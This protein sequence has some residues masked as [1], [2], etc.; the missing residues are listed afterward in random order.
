MCISEKS[1]KWIDFKKDN[2]L[3][4]H[5]PM[6]LSLIFQHI[7]VRGKFWVLRKYLLLAILQRCQAKRNYVAR[8]SS[9]TGSYDYGGKV[10]H[11]NFSSNTSKLDAYGL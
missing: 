5:T 6:L 4:V 2:A 3:I 11:L 1:R 7:K 10:Y 9:K 8:I